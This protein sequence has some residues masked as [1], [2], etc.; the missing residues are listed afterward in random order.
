MFLKIIVEFLAVQHKICIWEINGLPLLYFL[1][2]WA[3]SVTLLIN[4]L[5]TWGAR[6]EWPGG[7]EATWWALQ[8]LE[9]LLSM[10]FKALNPVWWSCELR[11]ALLLGCELVIGLQ[12]IIGNTTPGLFSW[13]LG[14]CSHQEMTLEPWLTGDWVLMVN[15]TSNWS[16]CFLFIHMYKPEKLNTSTLHD[17]SIWRI[18]IFSHGNMNNLT[19]VWLCHE[20]LKSKRIE[21]LKKKKSLVIKYNLGELC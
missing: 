3:S 16:S 18:M 10:D 19:N 17:S 6:G 1:L 5:L 8:S 9:H 13:L 21:L 15:T 12:Y 4:I 20:Q 11:S 7:K 14:Q 2:P